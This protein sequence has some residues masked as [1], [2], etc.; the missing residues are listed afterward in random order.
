MPPPYYTACDVIWDNITYGTY[1]D[2]RVTQSGSDKIMTEC[3]RIFLMSFD[4]EF[5]RHPR[6]VSHFVTLKWA[7]AR[8]RATL[9]SN[10]CRCN[11]QNPDSGGGGSGCANLLRMFFLLAKNGVHLLFIDSQCCF[12]KD[13][14]ASAMCQEIL[15]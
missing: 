13:R 4:H 14:S 6:E 10:S 8:A 12:G 3:V 11:V 7:R 9:E 15:Q 1:L 2:A 5:V